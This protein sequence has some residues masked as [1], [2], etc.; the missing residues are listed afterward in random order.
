[1]DWQSLREPLARINY[2]LKYGSIWGGLYKISRID[3]RSVFKAY[4][5][6][7]QD[8]ISDDIIGKEVVGKNGYRI[9]KTKEV[10]FGMNDWRITHIDVEL[11]DNIE[12][13]LGMSGS[14]LSHS[15]VPLEVSNIE[16]IG[17]VITL[18]TTK[19]ELVRDINSYNA[20]GNRT[21]P[22]PPSA[23]RTGTTTL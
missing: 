23:P 20:P 19:E 2:F 14:I 10:I 6:A 4:V 8:M 1:M 13:E 11:K 3:P 15:R 7:C 16:G 18:K 21:I 5:G 12:A 22:P 17:D 9:G